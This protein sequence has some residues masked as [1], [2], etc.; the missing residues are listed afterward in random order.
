MASGVVAGHLAAVM[1]VHV[2]RVHLAR[3]PAATSGWLRGLTDPVVAVALARMH[4]DPAHP[5]TVAALAE[6]ASVSRSTLPA[7]FTTA[8]GTGPLDYLARWRIE[9]AARRLREGSVPLATVARAVGYGSESALSVA[10]T[11]VVGVSPSAYRR[12]A[13]PR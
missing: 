11:R 9:L 2:L 8:V 13:G 7:R 5:W 3:D 4:A 10:F 12:G 6:R 1:L